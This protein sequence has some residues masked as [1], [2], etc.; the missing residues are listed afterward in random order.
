MKRM[1]WLAASVS[2]AVLSGA[3]AALADDTP[4]YYVSGEGGVS[5]L[6]D[7]RLKDTPSGTLHENFDAGYAY[8]GA[9]GYDTGAGMRFEIDSLHQMSN[10]DRLSGTPVNGH[11][12]STSVMLNGQMDLMHGSKITPYA[13]LGIGYQDVG[14]NVDGI[15][16][17]DWKPA[18]QAQAGLRT[19]IAH[20]VSLFGQY[21]FT[22]SEAADLSSGGVSA[23][24]HFSDHGLLAGLT[25]K[26]G[27]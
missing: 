6:P 16:D 22:Q 17:R 18:Y 23:H 4:G 24:Q 7:L 1:T 11:L 12:Q 14:A 9:L 20:N 3:G 26:L 5:L 21:Q 15:A 25:Y 19:D 13:G 10:L 27:E 8:G 2:V